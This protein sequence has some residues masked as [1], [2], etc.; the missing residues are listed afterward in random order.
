[1]KETLLRRHAPLLV[2]M[3]ENG[4]ETML[5]ALPQTKLPPQKL[6]YSFS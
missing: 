4:R 5:P 2:A 1:M 3:C 6:Q